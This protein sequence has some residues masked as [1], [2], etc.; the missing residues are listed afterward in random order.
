MFCGP[1]YQDVRAPELIPLWRDFMARAP[2]GLSSL[3]D[4]STVPDDP[5]YPDAVRGQRVISIAAVY[6][7]PADEG[8]ALVAPLRAYG[9]PLA[10][11]SAVMPYREIQSHF[12]TFFPKGRDRCYWKSLY[13]RALDDEVIGALLG[14]LARRPSEMTFG[15]I[16]ASGCAVRRV[17]EAATAFGDR[18]APYML[19][20]D[21]IWSNRPMMPPTS[22]GRAPP[23]LTCGGGTAPAGC[24]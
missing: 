10:D 13:L 20:F 23:G 14:H 11:F 12:D 24:I 1:V 7:G 4:F 15:S 6:D 16:W 2:D 21:A 8:D 18:S 9:T 5:A 19:S 3:V 17:P 22:S